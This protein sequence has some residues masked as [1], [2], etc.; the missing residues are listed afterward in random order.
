MLVYRR[1]ANSKSA[2]R[3]AAGEGTRHC[4]F[5]KSTFYPHTVPSSVQGGRRG[6]VQVGG[7]L[8]I[9]MMGSFATPSSSLQHS[10]AARRDLACSVQCAGT[11]ELSCCRVCSTQ[12]RQKTPHRPPLFALFHCFWKGQLNL[13]CMMNGHFLTQIIWTFI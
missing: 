8:N 2:S 7:I 6:Q 10:T 3:Q 13:P 11:A 4:H 1:W 9:V 12:G 5:T